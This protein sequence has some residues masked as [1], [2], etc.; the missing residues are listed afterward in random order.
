MLALQHLRNSSSLAEA[1]EAT[2]RDD[3]EK[4]KV[5]AKDG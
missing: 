3:G 2:S 4:I 5:G 1:G